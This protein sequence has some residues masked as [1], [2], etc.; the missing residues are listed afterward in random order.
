MQAVLGRHQLN[1]PHRAGWTAL[2]KG[3]ESKAA[4]DLWYNLPAEEWKRLQLLNVPPKLLKEEGS[5]SRGWI[6]FGEAKLVAKQRAMRDAPTALVD[7]LKAADQKHQAIYETAAGRI[8]AILAD[9]DHYMHGELEKVEHE[10]RVPQPKPKGGR[11][12]LF[13]QLVQQTSLAGQHKWQHHR[14]GVVCESCGKRI[15]ACS[16]FEEIDKKQATICPGAVTKT[17][18][19][20]MS[21]MIHDT[22]GMLEAQN[23]H[24]WEMT[25]TTFGCVRCWNKIP[26][27][28]S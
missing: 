9:R 8:S 14:Q 1:I 19:Q 15:K 22:E 4:P 23:G 7:E 6:Q 18:K 17:L 10:V 5:T 21:E 12:A 28:S 3:G 2:Q 20:V 27:R 26:L 25:A 16:T 11:V 24:K 13:N